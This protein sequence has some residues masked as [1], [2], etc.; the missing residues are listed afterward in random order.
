MA[1]AKPAGAGIGVIRLSMLT[2]ALLL[3]ACGPLPPGR[4]PVTGVTSS[5]GGGQ[6][7]LNNE[8][9]GQTNFPY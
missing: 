7:T 8:P 2:F 1:C 6:N 3:S 5:S 4:V 9:K